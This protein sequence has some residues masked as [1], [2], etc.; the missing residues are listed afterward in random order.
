MNYARVYQ[1][2]IEF[3]Q[4]RKHVVGYSELHHIKPRSL[5]GTN[6]ASNLVELT[7]R[8]HFIAHM[9]LA[10]VHGGTQWYAVLRLKGLKK[11]QVNSR[12]YSIARHAYAKHMQQTLKIRNPMHNAAVA[13]KVAHTKR[14]K[15]QYVNPWAT[16]N[17]L[18][19]T[20]MQDPDYAAALQQQRKNAQKQSAL[21]RRINNCKTYSL[22]YALQEQNCSLKEIVK[23]AGIKYSTAYSVLRGKYAQMA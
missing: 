13:L 3:A 5:G 20:R 8:E 11:Q 16:W 4:L 12:L 18:H 19:T 14:I 10:K 17:A 15:Q 21:R 22:L 7:A 6:D 2:L 9:L 23:L 1:Q